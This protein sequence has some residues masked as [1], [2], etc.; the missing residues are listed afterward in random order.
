MKSKAQLDPAPWTE[1]DERFY[2]EILLEA[3]RTKVPLIRNPLT[4]EQGY[5][6]VKESMNSLSELTG[7]D[8]HETKTMH[9]NPH[10]RTEFFLTLSGSQLRHIGKKEYHIEGD[11]LKLYRISPNYSVQ[12]GVAELETLALDKE[13]RTL[14]FGWAGKVVLET[15]DHQ[16]LETT[17]NPFKAQIRIRPGCL[18]TLWAEERELARNEAEGMYANKDNYLASILTE[19]Y[20][21]RWHLE[22][23]PT[24]RYR[25]HHTPV[26]EDTA[27]LWASETVSLAMRLLDYFSIVGIRK[28]T[29]IPFG[30]KHIAM[31]ESGA[32]EYT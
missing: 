13:T 21:D 31:D 29:N 12:N 3:N 7:Q 17:I 32:F 23:G 26:S 4:L 5:Q 19:E 25:P 18:E 24:I 8:C 9:S 30:W 20:L 2:A 1:T 15:P 14:S 28:P 16:F 27:K 22:A 10:Y 6:I 11:C